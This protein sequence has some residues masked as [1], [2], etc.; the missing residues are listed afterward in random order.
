MTAPATDALIR[1]ALACWL[2]DAAHGMTPTQHA[3]LTARLT[4]HRPLTSEERTRL[5]APSWPG[6]SA[7][8]VREW[9]RPSRNSTPWRSLH[10]EP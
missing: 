5:R 9:P 4:D 6:V 8:G 2:H 10:H 1:V 7:A 3:W